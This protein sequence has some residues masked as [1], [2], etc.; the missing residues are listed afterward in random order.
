MMGTEKAQ[1]N[2]ERDV[3]YSI[4]ALL[5]YSKDRDADMKCMEIWHLIREW[6]TGELK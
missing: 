3:I 5:E 6:E 4:K 2:G 1:T